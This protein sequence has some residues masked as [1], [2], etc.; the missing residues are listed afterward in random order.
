MIKVMTQLWRA[1]FAGEGWLPAVARF[2]MSSE[3]TAR[4]GAA[5]LGS[6]ELK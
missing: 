3:E 4:V 5:V 1:A 6:L 2:S